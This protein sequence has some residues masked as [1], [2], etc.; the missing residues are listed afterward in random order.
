MKLMEGDYMN[1]YNVKAREV[2]RAFFR[3][4]TLSFHTGTGKLNQIT[5]NTPEAMYFMTAKGKSNRISKANIEKA[6]S[7][8][9]SGMAIMRKHL[10]SLTSFSSALLGLLRRILLG[11]ADIILNKKGTLILKIRGTRFCFSG[12]DKVD[13]DSSIALINGAQVGMVSFVHVGKDKSE[14][15]LRYTRG[16][17]VVADSGAFWVMDQRD[18]GNDVPDIDIY[19]LIN[20]LHRYKH[21]LLYYFGLDVVGDPAASRRNAEI[22]RQ[23]GLDPIEVWHINRDHPCIEA[24][25]WE[26]LDQMVNEGQWLLGIGGAAKTH[27][28]H[29]ELLFREI[30]HRYPNQPFHFLGC[31]S[32]ILFR[33][34]EDGIAPLFAD[35]QTWA[36]G[37]RSGRMLTKEGQ[38]QMGHVMDGID[39]M[40]HNV[41]LLASM[42]PI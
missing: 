1:H 9:M 28:T 24:Q 8:L 22:M 2:V 32:K 35:S 25:N 18:K 13:R 30:L 40:A 41:R 3:K 12:M 42:S 33:F 26:L 14:K 29:R 5:G 21:R 10:E 4:P 15:W 38:K 20:W 17:P 31:G 11:K 19:Q 36:Q 7:R 16:L 34:L 23:H 39:I 27:D 6:M 37:R